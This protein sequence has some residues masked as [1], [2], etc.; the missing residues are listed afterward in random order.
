MTSGQVDDTEQLLHVL[1][2]A[3]LVAEIELLAELHPEAVEHLHE[4]AGR[5]LAGRAGDDREHRFEEI[6]VDRHPLLDAGPEHLD[7]DVGAVVET[8]TVDD[9]DRRPTDRLD[10]ELRE[11]LVEVHAEL[12]LDGSAHIVERHGGTGVEAGAELGGHV[13]AEDTR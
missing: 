11:R 5:V 6:H 8:G 9:G 10:V 2:G 13:V 3:G 4:L 1:D 12:G 7:G